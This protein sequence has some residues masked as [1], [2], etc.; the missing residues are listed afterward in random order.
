MEYYCAYQDRCHADVQE[1]LRHFSLTEIE[2][3]EVIVHLLTEGFLHEERFALAFAI[4]KFHQKL[5]GKNRIKNELQA[6][7]ISDYLIRKALDSLPNDEY[8]I[9][10][11][12]LSSQVWQSITEKNSLKKRKKFCDTLLRKG[13]ESDKVYAQMKALEK[14]SETN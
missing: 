2:R 8:E 1:K 6:R 14:N 13:W 11:E 3:Q 9:T 5:W 12:N 7:Q 4:G 10:F